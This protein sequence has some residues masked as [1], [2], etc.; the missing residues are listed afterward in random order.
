MLQVGNMKEE[1]LS[2]QSGQKSSKKQCCSKQ[3][4][5]LA[6][7]I[8]NAIISFVLAIF[9]LTY[10]IKHS[11]FRIEM[12]IAFVAY[13]TSIFISLVIFIKRNS[14]FTKSMHYIVQTILVSLSLISIAIIIDISITL[15]KEPVEPEQPLKL[16]PSNY[17]PLAFIHENGT[18]IHWS[19]NELT[20]TKLVSGKTYT[21]KT[22][23]NFHSVFVNNDKFDYILGGYKKKYS[24][25]LPPVI[26]K[27]IVMADIQTVNTYISAMDED[28]DFN[29]LCGD[30]SI[31]G[32]MYE[33]GESFYK[34]HTKPVLMVQG[35][36][37][38]P[39][40]IFLDNI[41]QRPMNYFQ[42]VRNLGYFF[43]YVNNGN[44]TTSM[45]WLE[46]NAKL[47]ASSEHVF[48][49]VHNPVYSTGEYGSYT[50]LAQ[51]ME[52]FIDGHP[53]LKVRGIFTGH[54]H[55]FA[56]FKRKNVFYFVNGAGGARIDQMTNKTYALD[57]IWP[58][59]ELHGPLTVLNEYC[60][61]YEYHLDSWMKFTRTEV[62]FAANKVIYTIRDLVT[63]QV[64]V[65]YDQVI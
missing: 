12:I 54:D 41:T 50:L 57:R 5:Q 27:F 21:D 17:G 9:C 44:T 51:K 29:V 65:T 52:A 24:Y 36:H 37:D 47:G 15:T 40:R 39:T 14:A 3:M 26:N 2:Q 8:C 62:T 32:D 43:I 4:I 35:N 53:E 23:S 31:S 25:Y 13:F 48:I 56:A 59:E 61:G 34:M 46:Q 20:G 22:E 49:V 6:V 30:Y 33:Y 1:L 63:K 28:Y 38:D 42:K 19:T 16:E 64:L 11:S 55:L 58:K 10:E 45:N 7:S 60:Y 18:R